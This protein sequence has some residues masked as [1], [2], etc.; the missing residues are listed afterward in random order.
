MRIL[1]P[2]EL[3]REEDT[4]LKMAADGK[5]LCNYESRRVRKDGQAIDVSITSSPVFNES[6]KV[7][8]I[9]SI[10]RDITEKKKWEEELKE[11]RQSAIAASRAKSDFLTNMSHE[12]RTPMNAIIG[13]SHLLLESN[14]QA[15]LKGF[16]S[17]IQ[18]SANMLLSLINDILDFSKIESEKME[19]ETLQFNLDEMLDEIEDAFAPRIYEKNLK[20]V[21]LLDAN[22]PTV[23][24]GDK[25]R[26]KQILMNLIGNALKF[27]NEGSITLRVDVLSSGQSNVELEL[28]IEDT[29]IGMTAGQIEKLFKP[30]E[31]ADTSTTRVYGGTGL[32]LAIC[33]NLTEL[34]GGTIGVTSEIYK[35]SYFYVRIPFV[36]MDEL[37]EVFRL[38]KDKMTNKKILFV[39]DHEE[40]AKRL[41][42]LVK[43]LGIHIDHFLTD[44]FLQNPPKNNQY[45]LAIVGFEAPLFDETKVLQH[46]IDNSLVEIKNI[47]VSTSS[48]FDIRT[49]A[50]Q[51]A[52]IVNMMKKSISRSTL[53]DILLSIIDR[54]YYLQT[55]SNEKGSVQQP[56]TALENIHILVV[57]DNSFNLEMMFELLSSYG[58]VVTTAIS[59]HEALEIMDTN[60]DDFDIIF[61]DLQ[62]PH[63]DGFET[64]GR[65]RAAGMCAIPIVALSADIT[66]QTIEKTG[67]FSFDGYLSKPIEP[68]QLI[69]KIVR[70]LG[71]KTEVEDA[72]VQ[73]A[74]EFSEFKA[75]D[76]MAGLRTVGGN[77]E[78]Y[79]KLLKKFAISYQDSFKKLHEYIVN[80][81][82]EEAGILIHTLKGVAGNFGMLGLHEILK[83]LE[84]TL[85]TIDTNKDL[86]TANRELQRCLEDIALLPDTQKSVSNHTGSVESISPEKIKNLFDKVSSFQISAKDDVM[87]LSSTLSD[88]DIHREA[89][90]KVSAL[91]DAYDFMSAKAIIEEMLIQ[92]NTKDKE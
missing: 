4:I 55:I 6:G 35:G 16:V 91:L 69:T 9:S 23:L 68:L 77:A 62:M 88:D 37:P 67:D 54:D 36:C 34:M 28:G 14:L 86:I 1:F 40:Y 89:L 58:A 10:I 33:K 92:T 11:A 3:S 18:S 19:M 90:Q 31:Q 29:G 57:D 7:V 85:H 72:I 87:H 74:D 81:Q 45:D 51:N 32:G 66:K 78:A 59:G 84:N 50:L 8:G 52:D 15:K 70:L 38:A 47:V 48:P 5:E 79:V 30:F 63:M 39:D 42:A 75:I 82:K 64:I 20:F 65:I 61:M 17:T 43:F 53:L 44:N 41:V 12:I 21:F 60:G 22:H 80:G 83:K 71:I 46:I 24:I 49:I 56:K 76:S 25:L 26:L 27:T 73:P 2:S 13:M